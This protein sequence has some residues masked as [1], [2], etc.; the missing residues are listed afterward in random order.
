MTTHTFFRPADVSKA[1]AIE[2]LLKRH[3]GATVVGDVRTKRASA[4][5]A[6]FASVRPGERIYEATIKISEEL[7]LTADEPEA[8]GNPFADKGESEDK[9]GDSEE[10]DD[11]KD[12]GGDSGEPSSESG[13]VDEGLGDDLPELSDADKIV[14]AIQALTD[15]ITGGGSIPGLDDAGPPGPEAGGPPPGPDAG[16]LPDIGAPSQG[17]PLPP[18]VP[19]KGPPAFASVTQRIAAS[20]EAVLVRHDVDGTVDTKDLIREAQAEFPTH[21]VARIRR[22]G[23]VDI[24]G[25]PVD[26]PAHKIALVSLARK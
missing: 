8:E 2:D 21:R 14:N 9:G 17:E 11:S 6:R 5:E 10:K 18:P 7:D 16:I 3:P 19:E 12:E 22:N 1:K 13:P 25:V 26:L 15:A 24:K 23:I 4:A 20:G